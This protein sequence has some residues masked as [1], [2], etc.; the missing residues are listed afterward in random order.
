MST[1]LVTGGTGALGRHVVDRLR[2]RG[3]EVRV[4]SR[5]EDA[6]TH[7]G[8][9]TTGQG[10]PA[11]VEGSEVIVHAASDFRRFGTPDL[12]QTRNLL[13]AAGG[14]RQLLYVSIVGI[15]RIPLGYYRNKLACEQLIADSGAPH[16]IL[17]ATQFHD[18]IAAVLG[19]VRRL[20]VAPLP[21]DFRFQP[22][23]TGDVATRI[24]DLAEGDPLGRAP[25]FGGPEVST[26]AELARVWQRHRGGPKH[27]LPLRLP[28]RVAGGFR[29]GANTCPE[30]ADGTRTW[31]DYVA[32]DPGPS[33]RLRG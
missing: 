31:A 25:D 27:L 28:G 22:V 20:P 24:A 11:A 12:A 26:L 29:A 17:R 21:T 18:L 15:D 1:V 30:H 13:A 14:V 2:T 5:R 7:T 4:L 32:A 33:Y 6:G 9:L 16:T 10:V 19:G 3:H 23:D 8:D